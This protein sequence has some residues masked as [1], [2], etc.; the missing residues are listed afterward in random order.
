[1]NTQLPDPASAPVSSPSPVTWN[2][3]AVQRFATAVGGDVS[4]D[5]YG[6]EI[7]FAALTSGVLPQAG[8]IAP[9]ADFGR[10]EVSGA[11]GTK[12]LH[13]QLT[14]DI[15]HLAPGAARWAGYCSAKG[16]LL[17]TLRCWRDDDAVQ[18]LVSRPI[19]QA[20]AKRLSMFVLRAKARVQD[21]SDDSVVFGLCGDRAGQAV[22]QAFSLTAPSA[23]AAHSLQGR[24]L[25]GLPELSIGDGPALPRWL[26]VVSQ[27]EAQ[28]TWSM[29]ADT[30]TA[31][32]SATWRRTEVLCGIPRIVSATSERFV[33]Q[34]I[35]YESVDGV[36]FTKGCY[37]GQE[38]VA[39]SQYL[40]KLKRRMYRGHLIGDEPQPGSDVLSGAD[41]QACGQIVLAAPDGIGGVDL[42]FESQTDA[43]L[44]GGL[45]THSAEI[46]LREL[47]YLLKSID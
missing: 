29:L 4:T 45:R 38:V 15:E 32:D 35:N 22:A 28:A 27:D 43:V 7:G 17:A 10:I 16:R 31:V 20:L 21:R 26:L 13:G 24:H 14:Q 1:M 42:L 12:F 39:R 18:L 36:N 44:A 37:P 9:L 41:G 40:G 3:E 46:S 23:Q 8:F 47:P 25:V 34:M 19:A 33:P 30:L 2:T 6:P 5:D 11:E